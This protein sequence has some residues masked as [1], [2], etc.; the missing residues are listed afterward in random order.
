MSSRL[1]VL[2]PAE[3]LSE[4]QRFAK[5]ESLSVGEWVRR[6]LREARL[7]RP[8]SEPEKK[9]KAIRRAVAHSFPTGDI[10][11]MLDEIARG[12]EN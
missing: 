10:A 11:Q 4:I 1:Q 5:R 6:A 9:I 12:Y 7:Q 8:V 3:E 2:L